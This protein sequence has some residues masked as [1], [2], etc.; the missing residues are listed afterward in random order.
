M[1]INEYW[2]GEGIDVRD[3]WND[4]DGGRAY[5][6]KFRNMRVHLIRLTFDSPAS[7]PLFNHDAI[8]KT[9]KRYFHDLKMLCFSRSDYEQAGPLFLYKIDRGSTV[10]EFLGELRQML[11]FGTTLSD[12]KLIGQRLDNVDKKLA[13]LKNH[14]G[15]SAR[16]E[17]FRA[18]MQAQAVPDLEEAVQ[19][20]IDQGLR[21][22]EISKNPFEGNADEVYREMIDLKQIK[23]KKEE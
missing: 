14:F 6:Q 20:M 5:E 1:S 11:L 13:I 22:V 4:Y 19:R 8:Y 2:I 9:V 16:P 23:S 18:F 3:V 17:D 15:V 12:Q 21:R 10:W 7:I